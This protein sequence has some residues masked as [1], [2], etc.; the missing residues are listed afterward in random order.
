[1]NNPHK[2]ADLIKAWADGAKIQYQGESGNWRD[3]T[4]NPSWDPCVKY[5]IKPE[6][7]VV[8]YRRYLS[9]D[10]DGKF[11]VYTYNENLLFSDNLLEQSAG[12]VKWLDCDWVTVTLD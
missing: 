11:Y 3:C 1:M 2:H 9:K 7:V 8:K 12:F 10:K 4:R 5:R 6:P